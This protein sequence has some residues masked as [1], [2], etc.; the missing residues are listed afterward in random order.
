VTGDDGFVDSGPAVT[1]DKAIPEHMISHMPEQH[2]RHL[3][4]AELVEARRAPLTIHARK[5]PGMPALCGDPGYGES[6]TKRSKVT[7][8]LCLE[9]IEKRLAERKART[10]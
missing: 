9:V 2:P 3:R 10:R 1:F 8:K 6:T 4:G 7:C 5:E